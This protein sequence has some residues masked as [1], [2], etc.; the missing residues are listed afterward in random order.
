MPS[1]ASLAAT[2]ALPVTSAPLRRTIAFKAVTGKL[3]KTD[4]GQI[5]LQQDESLVQLEVQAG[6]RFLQALGNRTLERGITVRALE[7]TPD[8]GAPSG[9]Y[10]KGRGPKKPHRGQGPK[11]EGNWA[12]PAGKKPYAKKEGGFDKPWADKGADRGPK[13]NK[14]F[15]DKPHAPG[16]KKSKRKPD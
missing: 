1:S 2:S 4:I 12:K 10:D 3:S 13:K 16:G 8:F 14:S 7:G 15:G 11:P 9:G 6:N 5:K